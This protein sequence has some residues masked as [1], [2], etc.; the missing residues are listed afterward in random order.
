[1]NA[2]SAGEL[3]ANYCEP[4]ERLTVLPARTPEG[5]RLKAQAAYGA[6]AD[7][8]VA[9]CWTNGMHREELA[10]L[11]ALRDLAGRAAA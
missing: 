1:V 7:V 8:S 5:R 6:I 11:S 9:D 2:F 4:L 3:W 10:A